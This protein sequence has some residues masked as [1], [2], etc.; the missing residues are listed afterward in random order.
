MFFPVTCTQ[1]WG[2]WEF[3]LWR[4]GHFDDVKLKCWKERQKWGRAREKEKKEKKKALLKW[5]LKKKKIFTSGHICLVCFKH[6][7]SHLLLVE[8]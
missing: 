8:I 4:Q 2:L 1:N 6:L 3:Y 7:K 5:Q